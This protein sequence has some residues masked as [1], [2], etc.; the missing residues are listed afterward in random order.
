[1]SSLEL[2]AVLFLQSTTIPFAIVVSGVLGY[3]TIPIALHFNRKLVRHPHLLNPL[4]GAALGFILWLLAFLFAQ[5][6]AILQLTAAG[7]ASAW[8]AGVLVTRWHVA[9]PDI[10]IRY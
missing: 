8:T 6:H 10:Q 4:A 7:A 5:S 9:H 1:M 3:L 2:F